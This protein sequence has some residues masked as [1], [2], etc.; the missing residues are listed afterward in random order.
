MPTDLIAAL[1][2]TQRPAVVCGAID[3][4]DPSDVRAALTLR[5]PAGN[6]FLLCYRLHS[7]LG[8]TRDRRAAAD[9]IEAQSYR[10]GAEVAL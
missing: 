5:S 2:P 10:A 3:A 8:W 4:S 7:E 6:A 1:H 9:R